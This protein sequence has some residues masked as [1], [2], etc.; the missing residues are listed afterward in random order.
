M[1][2]VVIAGEGLAAI[3]SMAP[4]VTI[5]RWVYFGLASLAIQWVL[6][7]TLGGLYL[8]RQQISTARPLHIAY[9]ALSLLLIATGLV[10][11]AAWA[12]LGESWSI[13]RNAWYGILLRFGGIAL[14]VGLLGLVAFQNH[15][16]TRQLA[17]QA[18][19]AELEALQAR[20]HP[21]FLFNTLNTGAA[22]VHQRP[23]EAENLL[24]DLADLFRA[25]LSGPSRIPLADELTLTRRYLEIEALRFGPR[26]RVVWSLPDTLPHIEVPTLSLQPLAENAIHHGV[27]PSTSGGDIRIEVDTDADT[28]RIR[29]RNSLSATAPAE[30]TGR[31]HVG[32]KSVQARIEAMTQG[33]G[34]VE[35]QDHGD[36]FIAS[37]TLPYLPAADQVETR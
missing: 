24:L 31:H 8:L 32:L 10:W 14:C 23:D 13:G 12:V 36:E 27:E 19:Q 37:I 3:L 9:L 17:V 1:T 26:L 4:G 11:L 30:G 34:R 7:L 5:D 28:V 35:T 21:H 22:L 16:R 18:K 20:I 2:W 29:V 33:R 15:W 25:A 6:L